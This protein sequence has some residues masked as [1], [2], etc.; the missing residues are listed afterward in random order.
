MRMIRILTYEYDTN[1]KYG[2]NYGYDMTQCG[3]VRYDMTQYGMVR[4]DMTQCGMIPYD[5][6]QYGTI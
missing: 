2:W 5:M 1:E 6:T 4:Y 3:M